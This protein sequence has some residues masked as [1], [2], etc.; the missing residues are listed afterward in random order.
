MHIEI[1]MSRKEIVVYAL[2][3][4]KE[5]IGK[6]YDKLY[7]PD[8]TFSIVNDRKVSMT[9]VRKQAIAQRVMLLLQDNKKSVNSLRYVG[10]TYSGRP[11][12]V[13]PNQMELF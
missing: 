7:H 2:E 5:A 11:K 3:S 6:P 8:V 9:I 10:A 4:D 1:V 12:K 13:N